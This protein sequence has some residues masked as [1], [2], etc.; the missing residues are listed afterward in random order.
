MI[1]RDYPTESEYEDETSA[2]QQLRGGRARRAARRGAIV[3]EN[4]E[5]ANFIKECEELLRESIPGILNTVIDQARMGNMTAAKIVLER[6]L[7]DP[8]HRLISF[9]LRKI[10]SVDDAIAAQGDV[11]GAFAQGKITLEET[12]KIT[13]LLQN[14][15]DAHATGEFSQRLA[16]LEDIVEKN[17]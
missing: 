7:P 1:I 17:K 9:D 2:Q 10:E 15:I 3:V 6:M 12:E 5:G 4:V 16:A 14:H 13:R 11:I 8:R